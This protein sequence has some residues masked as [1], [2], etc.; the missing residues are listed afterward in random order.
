M[1]QTRP[2]LNVEI[3]K[4]PFAKKAISED[5]MH[6]IIAKMLD[7]MGITGDLTIRLTDNYDFLTINKQICGYSESLIAQVDE[8]VLL[9]KESGMDDEPYWDL[10]ITS[11]LW[12]QPWVLFHPDSLPDYM[13]VLV[14]LQEDNKDEVIHKATELIKEILNLKISIANKSLITEVSNKYISA[15]IIEWNDFREELIELLVNR[16]IT[17]YVNKNYYDQII[18]SGP[19][20]NI[21]ELMRNDLFYENGLK[22]PSSKAVFDDNLPYN[23][24]RFRI[25]E[26]LSLPVIG[27]SDN[28]D[29]GDFVFYLKSFLRNYGYLCVDRDL[30]RQYLKLMKVYYPKLNELVEKAHIQSLTA[31]ILRLLAKEQIPINNLQVILEAILE[32]DYIIDYK[33]RHFIFDERIPIQESGKVG[34]KNKPENILEFVRIRLKRY[35]SYKYKNGQSSLS[36]YPLDQEIAN[37]IDPFITPIGDLS[38]ETYQRIYDAV[39]HA[40]GSQSALTQVPVILTTVNV[41]PHLKRIIESRFPQVAVISYQELSSETTIKELARISL[42]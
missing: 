23:A 11:I 4:C 16:E 28:T 5:T 42:V 31:K 36:F 30:V 22:Y 14:T 19:K 18:T 34:W 9:R 2:V 1:S 29:S 24:F 41:R 21:F 17:I 7:A 35:I 25:N 6:K 37:L 27:L 38:N 3:G 20:E 12:L 8:Y 40:L 13:P 10:I 33:Q 39:Q 26:F 32:S 15:S